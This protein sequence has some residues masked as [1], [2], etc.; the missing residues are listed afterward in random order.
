MRLKSQVK[1]G[2]LFRTVVFLIKNH[3]NIASGE[4]IGGAD[5]FLICRDIAGL[6]FI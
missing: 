1:N 4:R 6:L 5:F 3:S 2:G